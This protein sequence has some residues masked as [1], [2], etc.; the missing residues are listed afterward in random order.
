MPI[1]MLATSPLDE[2]AKNDPAYIA[3]FVLLMTHHDWSDE[4]HRI[5]CP[6]LVVVPGAEPIGSATNYEPFRRHVRNVE[7]RV[8]EG[9]PHNICD[10]FPDRCADGVLDF[11]GCRFGLGG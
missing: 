5:V 8:Y 2:A 10:A 6:T 4:L 7:M 1:G 3:K 9:A 11:L